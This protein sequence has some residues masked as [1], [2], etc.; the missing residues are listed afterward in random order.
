MSPS[1]EYLYNIKIK[2]KKIQENKRANNQ[3]EADNMMKQSPFA[4]D[5]TRNEDEAYVVR[6]LLDFDSAVL[7]PNRI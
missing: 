1:P 4:S 6:L 3:C 7:A 5:F 2:K